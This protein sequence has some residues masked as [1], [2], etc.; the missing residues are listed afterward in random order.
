[1]EH[2]GS[3][4][5]PAM[6]AKLTVSRTGALMKKSLLACA[7]AVVC[8][9]LWT[10]AEG[11]N[12]VVNGSFEQG[13]ESTTEINGG[14]PNN[15]GFWAPIGY[16][17]FTDTIPGWTVGGGGVDW[18]D[19]S[20]N[21]GEPVAEDGRRL[22]DLNSTFGQDGGTISQTIATNSGAPYVMTFFYSAHPYAGCYFGPKAMQASA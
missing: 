12:L 15:A 10:A 14:W 7:L 13:Y 5:G 11:A 21:P 16:F 8:G 9:G 3:S 6:P 1:M 19:S 17:G 2:R 20:P 18:H 4:G 22:V